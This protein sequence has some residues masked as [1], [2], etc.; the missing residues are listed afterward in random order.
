MSGSQSP[1]TVV[2]KSD[3]SEEHQECLNKLRA[4]ETAIELAEE[5]QR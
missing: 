1:S 4:L 2:K 3:P 5:E